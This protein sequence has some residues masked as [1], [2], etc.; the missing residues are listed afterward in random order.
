MPLVGE[1]PTL[2]A[3]EQRMIPYDDIDAVF[4]DAGGT[5]IGI[6]FDWCRRN[7]VGLVSR[8]AQKRL[9]ERRQRHGRE[10]PRGSTIERRGSVWAFGRKQAQP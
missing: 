3:D 7:S 6:D 9:Y 8:A 10:Y 4:F 2:L 5:L 1:S